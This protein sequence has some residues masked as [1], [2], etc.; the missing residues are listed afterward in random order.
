MIECAAVGVRVLRQLKRETR[1]KARA[2][3]PVL[4]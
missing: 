3:T 1:V 4:F 2:P